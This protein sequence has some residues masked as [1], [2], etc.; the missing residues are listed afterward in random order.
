MK[1]K[2]ISEL[3]RLIFAGIWFN[4][5]FTFISREIVAKDLRSVL[6]SIKLSDRGVFVQAST[7]GSL[8]ALLQFLKDS[9]IPVSLNFY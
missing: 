2:F 6:S 8:E 5:G 3:S 7:L 9:K 1:W 4:Q